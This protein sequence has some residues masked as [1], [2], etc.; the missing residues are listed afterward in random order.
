MDTTDYI[1]RGP[2]SKARPHQDLWHSDVPE[3]G[4]QVMNRHFDDSAEN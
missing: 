3:L 1:S 4:S 2:V